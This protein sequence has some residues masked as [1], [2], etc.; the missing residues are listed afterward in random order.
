MR[1]RERNHGTHPRWVT[2]GAASL[3]KFAMD[4]HITKLKR[5]V[6]L[7]LLT[8]FIAYT[9]TDPNLLAS[10]SATPTPQDAEWARKWWMPR[11]EEKLAEA[12]IRGRDAK[13]LFIGG[14]YSAP[15]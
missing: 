14:N 11:H 6:S 13:L 10:Q 5:I 9:A 7:K 12:K 2:R 4:P 8:L 3:T 15:I 1:Q